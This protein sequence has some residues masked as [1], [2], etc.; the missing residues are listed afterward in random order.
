M[1]QAKKNP[2]TKGGAEVASTTSE[3]YLRAVIDTVIA[4]IITIDEGR[5]VQTFN[6]AAERMFGY[7]ASEVIGR[8]VKML[9]PEPYHGEHDGYIGRYLRTGEARIIAF[10]QGLAG[11]P[12]E[13]AILRLRLADSGSQRA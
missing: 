13:Y 4:G 10:G 12:N 9:M 3:A 1:A 7:S 6:P 8:N 11:R 2:K 5:I